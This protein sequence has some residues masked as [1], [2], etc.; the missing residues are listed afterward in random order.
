MS[1]HL[2]KALLGDGLDGAMLG[3]RQEGGGMGLQRAALEAAFGARDPKEKGSVPCNGT[4]QQ[5]C[6]ISA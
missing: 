6:W 2:L 4:G 1:L 5:Q 3:S